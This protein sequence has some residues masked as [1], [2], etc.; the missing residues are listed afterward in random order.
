VVSAVVLIL[1]VISLNNVF[2]FQ[3]T[4]G[5]IGEIQTDVGL[6]PKQCFH[7]AKF[8]SYAEF[9]T[10]ALDWLGVTTW[11]VLNTTE[12]G[13]ND[14]GANTIALAYRHSVEKV[15]TET[16]LE[17][18]INFLNPFIY[19]LKQIFIFT[20]KHNAEF[21][22]VISSGNLYV[23]EEKITGSKLPPTLRDVALK[24]LLENPMELEELEELSDSEQA[25]RSHYAYISLC[26]GVNTKVE[27]YFKCL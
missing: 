23:Y 25:T 13:R 2:L 6:T 10:L 12:E 11:K 8:A 9:H 16:H 24:S 1:D 22:K 20:P 5:K 14:V 19:S 15:T 17:I 27:L 7:I 21:D 4:T 26:N 3:L 18:I